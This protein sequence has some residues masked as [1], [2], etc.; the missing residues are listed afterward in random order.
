MLRGRGIGIN[1]APINSWVVVGC[2]GR[3]GDVGFCW[4]IVGGRLCFLWYA[5]SSIK[6]CMST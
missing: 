2:V 5:F 1:Q 4:G 3:E 6:K